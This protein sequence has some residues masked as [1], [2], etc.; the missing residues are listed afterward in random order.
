MS[1]LHS[2]QLTTFILFIAILFS[3]PALAQTSSSDK[4]RLINDTIIRQLNA[5]AADT[6]Q[7]RQLL[8]K[9]RKC[10]R[11]LGDH[12]QPLLKHYIRLADEHEYSYGLMKSLDYLGLQ[13]RYDE[14]YDEALSLHQQSLA[15]ALALNDTLQM[16]YNY[17]N[18]AQAYRKQDLNA[19][20]LPYFHKALALQEQLGNTKS[21]SYTHNTLGAT[22]LSQN[23]FPKA[24]YHLAASNKTAEERN[25]IRTM[26]FNY[27]MMGEIHLLQNQ[28]DSALIYFL[29]ALEIKEK[30]NYDK[31]IAVTY[32]LMG[33]AYYLL[34][35]YPESIGLFNKAIEIHQRYKNQRYLALCYAYLG[36]INLD[37]KQFAKAH[38]NLDLA[39][40]M[41]N[42]VHSIEQL[43]LTNGA[44]TNLYKAEN[45]WEKAYEHLAQTNNWKD[46]LNTAKY[47]KEI[48][49]LEVNYQTKKKEQQIEI[50]SAANQIKNQRIRLGIAVIIIL[51]LSIA[52]G[53]YILFQRKKNAHQK[54]EKLRQQL[55]K[56]QMNP[57]FIFNALGSI[58]NYMYK[59]DA[60]SAARYRAVY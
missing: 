60:D 17:S 54:E 11:K 20:A 30:L 2:A 13:K 21:A 36:K 18:L 39:L 47:H 31:G 33:Q 7:M 3:N 16:C 14:H 59:N 43:I 45:N 26:S 34:N 29:K 15:I 6:A 35:N 41:A 52:F 50:L 58:Q 12:Y 19:L 4:A 37:Q 25:D 53:I 32:H 28:P 5:G 24:F 9:I 44:L 51:V 56:S 55:L 49:S 42:N 23:E 8:T 1:K 22:Y 38:S 40:N 46:S 27:G 48:Q 10:R 57:H